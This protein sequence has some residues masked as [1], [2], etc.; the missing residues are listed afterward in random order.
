MSVWLRFSDL[1]S[2]L[3]VGLNCLCRLSSSVK[4]PA[5][6]LGAKD[7]DTKPYIR[8]TNHWL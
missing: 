3:A 6:S 2:G 8:V 5:G 1:I 4:L 7:Y